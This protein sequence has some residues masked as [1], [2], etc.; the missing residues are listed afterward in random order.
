MATAV[1][2]LPLLLLVAAAPR[3]AAASG[4]AAFDDFTTYN[5]SVWAYD[6]GKGGDTDGCKVWYLKNHSA[7]NTTLSLGAGTGL[8]MLMS[9]TPCK[10]NPATCT[11]GAKMTADHVSSVENHHF[12]T[13]ELRMRAPYVVNGTGGTCDSG[14][15]AY[16]TAGY[17]SSGGRW[18]E[19][20]FGFHPDRDDHGT[21]VS[22]EHHDDSG[23][24]HETSVNLG[25]NYRES[26]NTYQIE[27]AKEGISWRVGHGQPPHIEM[28]TIHHAAAKLSKAMGTRL[29]MRTNFRSGDPGYMPDHVWEIEHFKFTPSDGQTEPGGLPVNAMPIIKLIG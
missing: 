8:R 7:V 5:A 11:N 22:C 6:D 21:R 4:G 1:V 24:Y 19:M 25:F 3:R 29:I 20:N 15:Y 13:Y 23:G 2:L 18:N 16:F 17:I 28:K 9:S 12:G 10:E 27:L 26:F 14:V